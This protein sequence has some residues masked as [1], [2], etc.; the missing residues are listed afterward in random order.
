MTK[1]FPWN[2]GLRA[3]VGAQETRM[4]A[5]LPTTAAGTSLDSR[6]DSALLRPPAPIQF[7]HARSACSA[8]E[9]AQRQWDLQSSRVKWTAAQL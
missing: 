3:R 8:A 4:E 6:I 2:G 9:M 5:G 1:E 7:W